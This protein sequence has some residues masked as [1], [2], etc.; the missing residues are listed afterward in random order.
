MSTVKA[1]KCK[2]FHYEKVLI[3][4]EIDKFKQLKT[5]MFYNKDYDFSKFMKDCL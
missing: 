5:N 3:K 1:Y 2:I 4:D